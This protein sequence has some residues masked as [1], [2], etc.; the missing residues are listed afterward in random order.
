MRGLCLHRCNRLHQLNI[1]LPVHKED[2]QQRSPT[3]ALRASLIPLLQDPISLS[4]VLLQK[5]KMPVS[6]FPHYQFFIRLLIRTLMRR[7]LKVGVVYQIYTFPRKVTRNCKNQGRTSR[8]RM[9]WDQLA[10]RVPR[11]YQKAVKGVH[12]RTVDILSA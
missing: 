1:L 12:L 11:C 4:A 5:A 9:H 2:Q 7:G 3:P 8:W 10:G 6:T